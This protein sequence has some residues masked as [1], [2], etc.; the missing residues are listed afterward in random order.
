MEFSSDTVIFFSKEIGVK[1]KSL[2]EA[3]LYIS[4]HFQIIY[5]FIHSKQIAH[6]HSKTNHLVQ[7]VYNENISPHILPCFHISP[8]SQLV[9]G[10]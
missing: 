2:S 10:S 4:V 3:V 1:N 9:T 8:Q 6:A 7:G 5:I